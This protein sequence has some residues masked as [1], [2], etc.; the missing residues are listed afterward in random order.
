M[1]SPARPF[2]NFQPPTPKKA[3]LRYAGSSVSSKSTR[4]KPA[5]LG[6]LLATSREAAARLA[7]TAIDREQWRRVVGERIAARTEPGPKRGRELTVFVASASWA[8]ELSLLVN[9]IVVRLKA[10]H[11]HVDTVRF[12]VREIAPPLRDPAAP[13][14]ASRKAPLPVKLQER[15][16]TIDDEELRDAIGEAASLWLAR[17]EPIGAASPT[18]GPPSARSPRAAESR[19]ARSDRTP[20]S[21]HV[22]A[23]GKP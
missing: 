16:A 1:P 8:Q 5:S 6:N 14:R 15:L 21:A 7:G 9:E 2:R 23:R 3:A 22:R 17:E 19:S 12:R 4:D 13:K 18:S 10:A 20:S 11:V